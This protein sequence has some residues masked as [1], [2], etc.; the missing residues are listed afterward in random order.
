MEMLQAHDIRNKHLQLCI[1]THFEVVESQPTYVGSTL[2]PKEGDKDGS[3]LGLSDIAK[4]GTPLGT[5]LGLEKGTA[6]G[7]DVGT[8]DGPVDG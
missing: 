6:D 7:I 3:P 5:S 1:Q 4:E 2:G 8:D